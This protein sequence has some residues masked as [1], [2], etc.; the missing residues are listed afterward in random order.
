MPISSGKE[1]ILPYSRHIAIGCSQMITKRVKEK[2]I[3]FTEK[4]FAHDWHSTYIASNMKGIYCIDE[5]LFG[6]RLHGNNIY[7]A[8]LPFK[9]VFISINGCPHISD[10]DFIFISRKRKWKKL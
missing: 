4:T 7:G 1:F 6:Y 2:M 8:R 10:S 5:P 9:K 3:P